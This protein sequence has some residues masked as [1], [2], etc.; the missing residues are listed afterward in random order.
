MTELFKNRAGGSL[1]P[2]SRKLL[3]AVVSNV[4]RM[5]RLIQDVLEFARIGHEPGPTRVAVDTQAV[6]GAVIKNLREAVDESGANVTC[7]SLPVIHA[8]EGQ[9]SRVFQ[10][11]IAN[12]IKYHGE[13]APEVRI[14]A[15][16]EGDEWTFSVRD[17]GIGIDPKYHHK[18]FGTFQRL[19]SRSE[20]EG[21]GFGLAICERIIRRHDGRIWVKSES[22][23][24]ATFYF[25]LPER[26]R[27]ADNIGR[28][29][30]SKSNP[31]QS[32]AASDSGL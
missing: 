31:A 22:G 14:S 20:Y 1:D 16:R 18:I 15:L 21:N 23:K 6:V 25:T 10:N 19:H 30:S 32:R 9:L 8:N 2:E 4:H 12:A 5:K 24:G 27:E 17:N 26:A 7:D 28:K 3:D 11:L 13:H 29:P